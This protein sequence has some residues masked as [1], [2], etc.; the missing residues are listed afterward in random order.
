MSSKSSG[1]SYTDLFL[2]VDL[3]W[4]ESIHC[5]LSIFESCYHPACVLSG[6]SC[7]QLF[8]MLWTIACRTP[9]D[10][11]GKSTGVGCHF[12][13]QG[14]LSNPEVGHRSV[15]LAGGVSTEPL[16]KPALD[17]SPCQITLTRLSS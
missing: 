6:F 17:H 4:R 5:L 13:L 1:F 11:P 10:S 16:G 7:V 15:P 12:L 2:S 3:G 8:V 14:N 9:W